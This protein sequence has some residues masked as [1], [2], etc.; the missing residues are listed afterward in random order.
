MKF[1]R[2]FLGLIGIGG[3]RET[4]KNVRALKLILEDISKRTWRITYD[5]DYLIA[6]LENPFHSRDDEAHEQ[7]I[8]NLK[9][10]AKQFFVDGAAFGI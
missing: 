3:S 9:A 8:K 10:I 1:L 4:Y 2:K 7:Y 5:K 6:T